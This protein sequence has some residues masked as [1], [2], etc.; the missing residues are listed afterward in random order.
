ME[1]AISFRGITLL[2]KVGVLSGQNE[3]LRETTDEL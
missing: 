1:L 2:N 3:G